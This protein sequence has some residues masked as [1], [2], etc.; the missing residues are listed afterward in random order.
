LGT[1]TTIGAFW[2]WWTAR[3]RS[4]KR[5]PVFDAEAGLRGA[6]LLQAVKIDVQ[7]RKKAA[8]LSKSPWYISESANTDQIDIYLSGCLNLPV[9]IYCTIDIYPG[10]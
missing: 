4:G 8:H 7:E 3:I 6:G 5:D 10:N 2:R 9:C 1:S